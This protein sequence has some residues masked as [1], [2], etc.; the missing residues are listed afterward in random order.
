MGRTA[1]AGRQ[2]RAITLVGERDVS[3]VHA[4][5]ERVGVQMTTC[6]DVKVRLPYIRL[7][8]SAIYLY[9]QCRALSAA[10]YLM[11]TG[12]RCLGVAE[13]NRNGASCR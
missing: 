10:G 1:R 7:V 4:I 8:S 5:E 9:C 11:R 12:K 13:R 6:E 3:L 2:G